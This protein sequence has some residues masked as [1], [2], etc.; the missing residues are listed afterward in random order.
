MGFFSFIG[1]LG[2][3]LGSGIASLGSKLGSGI[4]DVGKKVGSIT[5][6]GLDY[7]I[8]GLKT[9]TDFADKYTLGLT[10]FIPYYGAVKAGIDIAD[11]VR[12]LAKGEEQFGLG[13][14]ANTALDVV[15][16][17]SKYKSGAKE[18]QAWKNVGNIMKN[19]N[20][21]GNVVAPSLK[22]RVGESAR[23]LEQAY[24]PSAAGMLEKAVKEVGLT[25]Q[26]TRKEGTAT[27]QKVKQALPSITSHPAFSLVN[28]VAERAYNNLANNNLQVREDGGIYEGNVLVG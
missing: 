12:K 5:L 1:D 11:R 17:V 25:P 23:I 16:G 18:L 20:L 21:V 6:K 26:D 22:Q 3:K 10:S 27:I 2:K 15:S 13:F 14:L 24:K 8:Q 4:V 9:A 28:E 7:G 19:K